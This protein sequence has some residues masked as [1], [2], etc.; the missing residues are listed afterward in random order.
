MIRRPPRS[1][2]FP[3]TTL[4]RSILTFSLGNL[5]FL[6][7]IAAAVRTGQPCPREKASPIWPPAFRIAGEGMLQYP[8][9]L[10]RAGAVLNLIDGERSNA[11]RPHHRQRL[12]RPNCCDLRCARELETAGP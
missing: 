5:V 12:C 1:T 9:A 2:L 4:F 11:Q 6:W 10:Y 8:T 7:T 3:Y